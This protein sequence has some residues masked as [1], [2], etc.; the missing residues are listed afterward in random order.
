[1]CL[2]ELI[3]L[4]DPDDANVPKVGYKIF[5]HARAID[6]PGHIYFKGAFE[7]SSV[8]RL[9][10]TYIDG[11]IG[12]ISCFDDYKVD[13]PVGYHSYMN[14]DEAKKAFTEFCNKCRVTRESD[15]IF[16]LRVSVE[17]V[18]AIGYD[19]SGLSKDNSA[20]VCV[21]RV[22]TLEEILRCA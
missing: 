21:S 19:G 12:T 13:Y 10:E 8:Y 2:N 5:R 15:N 17:N 16:L 14:L 9:G 6:N 22:M 11:N 3:K 4:P 7:C 18:V 20:L 1:M